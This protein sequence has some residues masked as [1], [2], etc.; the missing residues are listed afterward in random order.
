MPYTKSPRTF[1]K[2]N[3][4]LTCQQKWRRRKQAEWERMVKAMQEE[5]SLNET[6][7][8]I[9]VY[10]PSN[11]LND[12]VQKISSSC[13]ECNSTASD[14]SSS[15]VDLLQE[16]MHGKCGGKAIMSGVESLKTFVAVEFI[17]SETSDIVFIEWLQTPTECRWP[18]Q[19]NGKKFREW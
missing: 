12:G 17:D 5:N 18:S 15:S 7:T 4:S 16:G 8:E 2:P 6:D 11:S 3:H 13:D 19:A 10:G 1:Y 9:S 14:S